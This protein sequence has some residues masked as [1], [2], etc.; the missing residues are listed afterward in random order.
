MYLTVALY[1]ESKLDFIR[2]T[3]LCAFLSSPKMKRA[4]RQPLPLSD[5]LARIA[6]ENKG[7]FPETHPQ[8]KSYVCNVQIPTAISSGTLGSGSV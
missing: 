7:L 2:N 1:F 3:P 8:G 6:L 4:S 5:R